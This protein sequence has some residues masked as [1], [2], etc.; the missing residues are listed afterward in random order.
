VTPL[1][2]GV[3]AR[4]LLGE[5]TG[6][7]RYLWELLRRWSARP[8]AA[9]RRFVLYAPEPLTLDFPGIAPEQR[10]GGTGR[11]TWWEQ[12]WLRRRVRADRPSVFF[13]PAYTAPVGIGVPLAVTIHDV[14]FAARPD[15]F[16]FREGLRRRWL[17][18]YA[19][20]SAA[21]VFT[22]SSFSRGEIIARLGTA[23]VR[24]DV[25]PPGV[26]PRRGNTGGP[27]EPIVLFVGSLFNRRRLPDL[28][29]AFAG[30]TRDLPGARLVIVGADRTWPPQD[31]SATAREHGVADRT[32]LRRYVPEAELQT[33][34]NRASAFAFLSEYE[35][36]GLPPL[37]AM[38]A[39]IPVVVLDTAVAREVYG[40]AATYVQPGD[41]A[42]TAAALRRFLT[43]SNEAETGEQIARGLATAGRY[44]WDAAAD[45]TLEHLERIARR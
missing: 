12:T 6:V 22:D 41:I 14:S 2:I 10:V 19:A 5:T 18:R 28:I 43:R 42:G 30:A 17:T 37:E 32:D 24:L 21:M 15:W 25:I 8:D 33:L 20:R 45:A 38:T 27:R 23:P 35:G 16:R 7:G 39:G 31:L 11:G 36:F 26:T 13:A 34:Y 44:S 9:A 29:A 3:D 40:S 1:T 4:E